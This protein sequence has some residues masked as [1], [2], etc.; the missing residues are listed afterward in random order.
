MIRFFCVT[1]KPSYLD[2][3]GSN[4]SKY[5]SD[6]RLYST[7]SDNISEG[8]NRLVRNTGF[9][10]RQK[11]IYVFIHQDCR[12]YFNWKFSLPLYFD[13]LWKTGVVGF[14]GT[15]RLSVSEPR[16]YFSGRRYGS[17]IQGEFPESSQPNLRFDALPGFL[18]GHHDHH[19]Q[20]VDS[21]DGYCLMITR[22]VFNEIGGFDQRFQWHLYDADICMNALKHG[23]QNYVIGQ[24]S[25][26]FSPG[27][28][29]VDW[30]PYFK[31]FRHK[32]RK[33]I[34]ERNRK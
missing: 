17:L 7:T 3:L 33:W 18:I 21:V 2:E 11:E 12:L 9:S 8:Y 24:K 5:D 30:K 28:F 19:F 27:D 6:V 23:Y 10:P 13:Q 14:V 31:A 20:P 15:D 4:L 34:E 25:C 29:K 22:D 32:W 16:W 1:N 26:H